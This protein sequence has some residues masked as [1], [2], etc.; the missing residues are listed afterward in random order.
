MTSQRPRENT[1]KPQTQKGLVPTIYKEFLKLHSK[2]LVK[3]TKTNNSVRKWAKVMST[4][5]TEEDTQM[6]NKPMKRCSL[7]LI[8][9]EEKSKPRT[10]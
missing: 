8:I 10:F 4:H 9:R 5:F 7:S 1:C 2:K 3:Q 6:A